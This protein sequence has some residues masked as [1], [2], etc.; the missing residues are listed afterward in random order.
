[1]SKRLK[2][3]IDVDLT[4]VDTL[5]PWFDWF[6]QQTG[7]EFNMGHR[8]QYDCA[9]IM[10]QMCVDNKIDIDPYAFWYQKDLYDN[11]HPLEDAAH[12]INT[13]G[14]NVFD[15]I[16]VSR[17]EPEHERSKRLFLKQWFDSNIPFI[18]TAR[19]DLVTYDIL[20]DDH[21]NNLKYQHRREAH[22]IFYNG[23]SQE[24]FNGILYAHNLSICSSWNEIEQ[25]LGDLYDEWC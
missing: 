9:P 11:I 15:I 20:I 4:V 24:E 2:L 8:Y 12:F 25:V 10:R 17:C 3:A 16:W 19:K 7:L 1:M 18:S 13:I 21:L 5:N 23:V 14:S 6:K 22:H